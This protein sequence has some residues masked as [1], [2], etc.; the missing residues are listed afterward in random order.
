MPALSARDPPP[1]R[2]TPTLPGVSG[3]E[4]NCPT[5]SA[6]EVSMS[7]AWKLPETSVLC[8]MPASL[9]RLERS[10]SIPQKA[11]RPASPHTAWNVS[12]VFLG[13]ALE[14]VMAKVLEMALIGFQGR[15][16]S[17]LA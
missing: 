6:A 4:T 5:A 9:F 2:Q 15:N 10:C 17:S 1:L 3:S 16:G 7:R 11:I 8:N 14:G 12:A 13:C